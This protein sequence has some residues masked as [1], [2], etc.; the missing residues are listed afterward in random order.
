MAD[1]VT[2]VEGFTSRFGGDI[3]VAFN[4]QRFASER[5]PIELVALRSP[6]ELAVIEA[7]LCVDRRGRLCGLDAAGARR[8]TVR[9]IPGLLDQF[10]SR[11]ELIGARAE[12]YRASGI[13]RHQLPGYGLAGG[14]IL[15]DGVHRSTAALLA[16]VPIEVDLCV[17]RGPLHPDCLADLQI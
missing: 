12:H 1:Q 9:E 6:E 5:W 4:W 11:A 16:E 15:M 17:V 2:T 13:V 14:A 10:D 7:P 3:R 8:V